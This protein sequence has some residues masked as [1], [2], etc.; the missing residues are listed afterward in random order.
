MASDPSIS[1]ASPGTTASFWKEAWARRFPQITGSYLVGGWSIIQFVDWLV[2]RYLLSPYLVDLL[3]VLFILL[4]PSVVML[5]WNHGRR[6][7]MCR[8]RSKV[9]DPGKSATLSSL[10]SPAMAPMPHWPMI[11]PAGKA[12]SWNWV[13]TTRTTAKLPC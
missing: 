6:Y 7:A 3:L 8:D 9:M 5:T 11:S 13:K 2:K 12:A 1:T 10:Y 4:L